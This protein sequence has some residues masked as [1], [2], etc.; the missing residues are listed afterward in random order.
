MRLLFR[1][2]QKG[3][4]LFSFPPGNYGD[5]KPDKGCGVVLLNKAS[6]MHRCHLGVRNH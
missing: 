3:F 2:V 5:T 6:S 4:L 1:I